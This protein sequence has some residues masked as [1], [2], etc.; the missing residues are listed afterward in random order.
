MACA[1]LVTA[2]VM[3]TPRANV[4]A[5]LFR[6]RTLVVGRSPRYGK[7]GCL[8]MKAELTGAQVW[9]ACGP[10]SDFFR[11][12][13]PRDWKAPALARAR[14]LSH[15]AA[16]VAERTAALAEAAR[17]KDD[18]EAIRLAITTLAKAERAAGE[19]MR[20]HRITL[21]S[22]VSKVDA[23]R[24]K[25]P[26]AWSADLFDAQVAR[27]VREALRGIDAAV[28]PAP[29]PRPRSKLSRRKVDGNGVRSRT[30]T[31]AEAEAPPT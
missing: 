10:L 25:E 29:S 12:P 14:E 22:G 26:A 23:R 16:A 21:P 30:L 1:R 27:K 20:G 19:L 17:A 28:V 13:L 11:V 6:H 7:S 5:I 24:W 3:P 31:A 15:A 4:W 9:T 8:Q 2:W 18:A